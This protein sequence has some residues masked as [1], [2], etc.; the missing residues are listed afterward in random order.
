MRRCWCAV[1]AE[2]SAASLVVVLDLDDTLYPEAD[3]QLSGF[4]A[5]CDWLEPLYG[6]LL[7]SEV[8]QLLAQG[9]CDVLGA[10]CRTLGLPDAVKQ[11]LLWVYRLHAPDIQLAA[12]VHAA[13][14]EF[15]RRCRGVA[16]LTDGRSVTQRLKL[17]ALG[18]AHLPVYI[19]EEHGDEKPAPQRFELVMRDMPAAQYVYIGDNPVKDFLA[20]N[21]LGWMTVGVRG[22]AR[23]V[24]RQL[25]AG[26]TAEHQPS[27]WVDSLEA[28]LLLE[29]LFVRDS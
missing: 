9:E 17:R 7:W 5:V 8:E 21:R 4:R 3:Y 20:P 14:L 27:A 12:G 13:V 29:T 24:H 18:L 6:H 26:L 2:F 22:G 15:Q 11:S 28:V 23:N 10:L 1:S 25:V 16:V 19:S